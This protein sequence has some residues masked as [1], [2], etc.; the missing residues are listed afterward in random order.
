MTM[1]PFDGSIQQALKWSQNK[2]PGISSII[3]R[4]AEW[5]QN[6]HDQ[7]WSGWQSA[8]FDIRTANPFGLM[9]WCIILGV[10]SAPFGLYPAANGWGF[11]PLRENFIHKAGSPPIPGSSN[12][13][14]TG[15]NFYGGG[16][17]EIL[18][19]DEVRRALQTRYIALVS[20]GGVKF[21]NRMLRYI[22][23]GDQ[24]WDM[25]GGRY[26]YL[27]DITSQ[28]PTSSKHIVE[29]RVGPNMEISTQLINVLNDRSM[30][31]MPNVCGT[32]IIVTQE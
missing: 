32:K 26:F 12:P 23:N 14:L 31:I 1:T 20:N 17:K 16:N 15:G 19:M 24:P 4:K 18:N 9:V 5:Y 13:N 29:Y 3:E 28:T 8:V 25:Q 21:I 11:G 10:P 27:A 22:W 30:G 2:A 7:F 6:N